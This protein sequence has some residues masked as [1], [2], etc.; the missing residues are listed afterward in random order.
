M[1]ALDAFFTQTRTLCAVINA[2]RG[3]MVYLTGESREAAK[4]VAEFEV[5]VTPPAPSNRSAAEGPRPA[6]QPEWRRYQSIARSNPTSI[7]K[8]GA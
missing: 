8:A 1:R 2:V 4:I 5:Q 7:R 3:D 6:I